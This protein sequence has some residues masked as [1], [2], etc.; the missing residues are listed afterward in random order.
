MTHSPTSNPKC[1]DF[2]RPIPILDTL[3][4]AADLVQA[5]HQVW[6]RCLQGDRLRADLARV[7]DGR[8]PGE[9]GQ[10]HAAGQDEQFQKPHG[11]PYSR[12]LP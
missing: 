7:H 6:R 3:P 4:G 5:G 11:Q 10:I 9:S 8:G 2:S 1:P 12:G